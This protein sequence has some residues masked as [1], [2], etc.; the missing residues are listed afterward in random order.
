MILHLTHNFSG[1][2]FDINVS[3]ISYSGT[4][5][6][7]DLTLPDSA[8]FGEYNYTL[9]DTEEKQDVLAQGIIQYSPYKQNHYVIRDSVAWIIY[10]QN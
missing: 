9:F 1:Q 5:Y 2:E 4:Y 10:D 3:E 7:F 8:P 6:S